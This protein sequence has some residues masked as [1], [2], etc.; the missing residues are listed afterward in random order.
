MNITKSLCCRR[1]S[2]INATSCPHCGAAF[3]TGSLKSKAVAE[4]KAFDRKARVL[5][6]IAFLAVPAV[7]FVLQIQGFL[8]PTS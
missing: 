8:V 1:L 3:Q 5:F 4:D 6:I 7:L 2:F